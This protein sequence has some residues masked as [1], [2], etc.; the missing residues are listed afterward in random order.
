MGNMMSD[1]KNVQANRL[2]HCRG[3]KG[4]TLEE[5]GKRLGVTGSR[6]SNWEQALRSPKYEQMIALAE[7]FGTTPAWLAGFTD[8]EGNNASAM[9]YV[10][11]DQSAISVGGETLNIDNVANRSALHI[12][13]VKARGLNENRLTAIVAQ[14]DSMDPLIQDGAEVLIDR[15]RTTVSTAD[16]FAIL[17]NGQIWIR[18]IR[19]ELDGSFTVAAEDSAHYPDQKLN[20]EQL[21]SLKIV[22][23][24]AR[25]THDR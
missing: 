1:I 14:G 8:H 12:D 7:L 4:W 3:V 25:I 16:L 22:G 24:I 9:D 5:T 15:S 20:A 2:R 23:R 13:H 19:P 10:T 11:L 17:V 6:Y 18:W 21:A